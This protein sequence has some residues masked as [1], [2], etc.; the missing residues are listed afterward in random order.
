M[1]KRADSDFPGGDAR[2]PVGMAARSPRR[3][4]PVRARARLPQIAA[5]GAALGLLAAGGALVGCGS[6]TPAASSG[7]QPLEIGSPVLAGGKPIPARFTCGGKNVSPPLVWG[8]VP[9]GTSELALFLLDL[10]HTQRA[11]GESLKA[12]VT[13]AWAV[14]GIKPTLGGM[15]AGKLPAGAVDGRARY[16]ICPPKGGSGEYMFRLYALSS[17]LVVKPGTSDLALFKQVNKAS[18]TAGYFIIEDKRS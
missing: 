4:R 3:A 15:G 16:S 5:R 7:V 14:H 2:P 13:V 1:T 11:G 9:S 6:V 12:A 17:P 18:S 8:N 10:S